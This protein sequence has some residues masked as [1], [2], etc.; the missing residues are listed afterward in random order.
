MLAG[1]C[2]MCGVWVLAILLS[3][4]K[5]YQAITVLFGGAYARSW[6]LPVDAPWGV[7]GAAGRLRA[8]NFVLLA[9][10]G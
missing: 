4:M 9:A 1:F 7:G 6:W 3:G 2:V 10:C 8:G 5:R